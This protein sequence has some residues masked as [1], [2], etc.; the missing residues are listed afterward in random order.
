MLKAAVEEDQPT[1]RTYITIPQRVIHNAIVS[2]LRK[3]GIPVPTR[4]T[5]HGGSTDE[6]DAPITAEFET[7]TN[8]ELTEALRQL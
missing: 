3:H 6:G 4:I 5:F 1:V 8:A 7:E 2:Y